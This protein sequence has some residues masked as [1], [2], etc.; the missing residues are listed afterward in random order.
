MNIICVDLILIFRIN[1]Q[2]VSHLHLF[3]YKTFHLFERKGI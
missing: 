1:N 3:G 2:T